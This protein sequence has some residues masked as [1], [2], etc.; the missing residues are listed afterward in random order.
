[1]AAQ[2]HFSA[3]V[4]LL[5]TLGEA[6]LSRVPGK[7]GARKMREGQDRTDKLR[8]KR[9]ERGQPHRSKGADGMRYAATAT[10]ECQDR[11]AAGWKNGHG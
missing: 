7:K 9:Q 2:L 10:P 5:R 8:A 1:M 6:T 11:L 4:K 3:G